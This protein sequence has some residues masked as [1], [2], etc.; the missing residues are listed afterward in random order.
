LSLNLFGNGSITH[1][2]QARGVV[3]R[4]LPRRNTEPVH[5]LQQE[6]GH[7]HSGSE[8]TQNQP[9]ASY[10]NRWKKANQQL[11]IS[12]YLLCRV[13][14]E[15]YHQSD[16][17]SILP[18]K[19]EDRIF[20]QLTR[21]DYER[22]AGSNSLFSN[23]KIYG[24]L[25]GVMSISS[26]RLI[27]QRYLNA[28]QAIQEE[29]GSKNTV[30]KEIEGRIALLVV[31][32]KYLCIRTQPESSWRES[33]EFLHALGK[34]LINSH[35]QAIKEQYLKALEALVFPVAASAS[36]QIATPKWKEFLNMLNARLTSMLVKPRYWLDAFPLSTLM[37]CASPVEVFAGQW[38][39]IISTLQAKLKERANRGCALQ[40]ICWLVW[41]Y[42]HRTSEA[43]PIVMRKLEDVVKIVLPTGKKTYISTDPMVV[44]PIV[45]LIRIIGSRFPEFCFKMIIFPL[46]NSEI[47]ATSRDVKAEQLEPERVVIGIKGFLTVIAGLEN[48]E[49]SDP[50]FPRF[51]VESGVASTSPNAPNYLHHAA[52]AHTSSSIPEDT[53]LRPVVLTK[54]DDNCREYYVR[55]CEILGKITLICDYTFGGQAVLDE[56]FGGQPPPKTPIAESFTF[57]RKDE[58]Y[59]GTDA[60]QAFY[61]LL[62]VAVQ[63]LPRCLSSHIPFNPLINLLCTGT[64]HVQNYIAVSSAR[65][66]KAIAREAHAQPVTIGFARFIFNFDI[67][68]STMSDEGMLGP[69]HIENTLKLY[70]ELLQIWIEEIREKT[71]SAGID[72]PQENYSM[73]RS[74]QLDLTNISALVEEVES[75]GVFFLCSQS[76]KV[77]AF[78]VSVLRLVTEFDTA[79]GRSNPRIIQI[80]DGDLGRVINVDDD[81][82][83]VAERSRLQKE[84]RKSS[85]QNTLIELCSSV[86]S[87]DSTLWFKIYPNLI[88]LSLEMC[89]N[90]IILGREIVCHRLYQM[91][92]IVSSFV[93]AA[94]NPHTSQLQRDMSR[95]GS[96]SPEIIVEQWKLYLIMACTTLTNAGAQTQNQLATQHMRSKSKPPQQGQEKLT[97]ARSLFSNIIPLLGAGPSSIRDAIVTALG[98]VNIKLYRTLL[99]SLQYA[100]TTCNE[101]ARNRLGSHQRSDSSPQKNRRTDRLRTEVTHVYKLTSR[102]LHEE[103]VLRDDW[104]ISNLINY[105]DGMRIFLS[106]TTVQ[107][108]WEF[109][110]LRRHYCGLMEEVFEGINR[111]KEPSRWMSFQARIAAFGLMED[112]CGYSPNQSEVTLREDSMKQS[113]LNQHRDTGTR[114][115]ATAAIEVEKRD[116]RTAALSAMA[117]LCVSC[118]SRSG[119][120]NIDGFFRLDP[121]VLLPIEDKVPRK[122]LT[123]IECSLG[124]IRS[125]E[126]LA[127]KRISLAAKL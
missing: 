127:I 63:A 69:G 50:R 62:H 97:S 59:A 68:Y 75:H 20:E 94:K 29:T 82:L 16:I 28:L 53:S 36:A 123:Y 91:Q 105:T 80:L 4:P 8:D 38:L 3:H 113:A 101:E 86:G 19:L 84:Q 66:L 30:S 48:P 104:I 72:S 10:Y 117:S 98:S 99:E 107:N 76:R 40:A 126:A 77:R 102:Y 5:T 52:E 125:S 45:Q 124:L 79:L 74:L 32:T 47:F 42:L 109:Q 70:L 85:P 110:T 2:L 18:L 13:L 83:T 121:S 111:L 122:A 43:I 61:E 49:S 112:W 118:Q 15:V 78:A 60:K 46:I 54:L 73:A 39:S 6:L 88:R 1:A 7:S 35:G 90:A 33:C 120:L 51:T 64:A 81:R 41:T 96:T 27:S 55:F 103:A 57:S 9:L 116:L 22:V 115:N 44:E 89:P 114:T 67:R 93:E 95:V 56:K 23:W 58:Q 106:D 11:N 12:N 17:K 37:L 65:S 25:L 14:I 108:D 100:V 87:Y 34:L 31:P 119:R 71:K 26:F 21:L 92:S 24:Q